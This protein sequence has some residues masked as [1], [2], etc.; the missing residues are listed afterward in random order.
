MKKSFYL[1]AM[2]LMALCTVAVSCSK[3]DGNPADEEGDTPQINNQFVG[4]Y[5]LNM[6]YDSITTD[7]GT[8]YSEEFYEEMT[9]KKN[10]PESG[11]LIVEEGTEGKLK[12]TAIFIDRTTAEDRTFFS[13]SATEQ[14]G[15]IV[16]ED[17]ES[18]YYSTTE[19]MID[20]TFRT[21]EVT[22]DAENN[23]TGL[24]FKSIYTINLGADYSYLTSYTCTKR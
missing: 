19:M 7:D 10:P 18:D 11:R 5:D 20:F 16:L 3:D 24:N 4:T 22:R 17:C 6:V 23:V 13:T 14:N 12:V 1:F 21:V 9:G 8:W 15:T 2:A